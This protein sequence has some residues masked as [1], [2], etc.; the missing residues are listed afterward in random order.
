[1]NPSNRPVVIDVDGVLANYTRARLQ[2]IRKHF[3]TVYVPDLDHLPETWDEQPDGLLPAMQA[4]IASRIRDNPSFWSGLGCLGTEDDRTAVRRLTWTRE[5]YFV[6]S[7]EGPDVQSRTRSWLFEHRFA[8]TVPTVCCTT[9]KASVVRGLQ[10]TDAIDDNLDN[11]L[12]MAYTCPDL[13]VYLLDAPYNRLDMSRIGRTIHRVSTVSEF[14]RHV[15][16][17]YVEHVS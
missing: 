15:E 12:A 16:R 13:R 7:R 9:D 8:A 3:P 6:T 2:L 1:M 5:V 10:A 14:V 11:A 4:T 17:H